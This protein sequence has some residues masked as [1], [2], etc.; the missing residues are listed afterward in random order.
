MASGCLL[1]APSVSLQTH[2]P[3][4]VQMHQSLCMPQL[5][6]FGGETRLSRSSWTAATKP[7]RRERVYR[8]V[9]EQRLKARIR[10]ISKGNPLSAQLRVEPAAGGVVERHLDCFFEPAPELPVGRPTHAGRGRQGAGCN[11]R[12]FSAAAIIDAGEGSSVGRARAFQA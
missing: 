10:G 3:A 4:L 11:I 7:M 6:G 2:R 12:F 9:A 8:E 5:R 1:S